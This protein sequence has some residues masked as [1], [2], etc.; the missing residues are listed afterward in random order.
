MRLPGPE[1]HLLASVGYGR[2]W[3]SQ[4]LSA[5]RRAVYR[6]ACLR[7]PR[8]DRSYGCVYTATGRTKW[9]PQTSTQPPRSRAG[10]RTSVDRQ[11]VV[12][13]RLSPDELAMLKQV[14][15]RDGLSLPSALREGFLRH[16]RDSR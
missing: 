4:C 12:G 5:S 10:E 13:V 9:P 11:A 15:A 3:H 2:V 16:A 1:S 14:A 6:A 7:V 8:P